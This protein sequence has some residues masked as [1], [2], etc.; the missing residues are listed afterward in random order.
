MEKARDIVRSGALGKLVVVSGQWSL[1]KHD[2]YYEEDWRKQ[3]QAGPVLTNFIHEMDTLRYICGE[4]TSVM[5]Q[6]SNLVL[7]Y[8]KEDA[9][10]VILGFEN[11][12][13]GTFALS[14]QANSPWGWEL[15]TGENPA[16]PKSGQNAVHFMGI[17][18]SLDFPN[19][20]LW[21]HG[22]ETADWKHQIQCEE[23]NVPLEDAFAAQINHFAA[24]VEG[25]EP[26]VTAQDATNS[27]RVV[28]AIFESAKTGK[29]VNL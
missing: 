5:A 17:K 12:A 10:A 14:D 11:G 20:K 7:G 27:L 28:L 1:R 25:C 26:R 19:L 9:A 24:V 29:R 15:A 22:G 4:T 3:W 8:E 13:L 21:H 23:I 18:A 6:T 16:F 2:S